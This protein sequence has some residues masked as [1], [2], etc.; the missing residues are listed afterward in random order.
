ML[1]FLKLTREGFGSRAPVFLTHPVLGPRQGN[2]QPPLIANTV[3]VVGAV[4]SQGFQIQSIRTLQ[5]D[6]V[7]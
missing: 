2:Y 7:E 4:D 6:T 3:C 1:K 5:K